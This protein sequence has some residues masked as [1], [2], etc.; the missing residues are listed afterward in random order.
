MN[1]FN[2]DISHLVSK[3]PYG[4]IFLT[5]SNNESKTV[6]AH[7]SFLNSIGKYHTNI[8][9]RYAVEK[10]IDEIERDKKNGG[11]ITITL[12]PRDGLVQQITRQDTDRMS[13]NY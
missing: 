1:T 8:E 7:A 9:A 4:K 11:A 6:S 10:I 12:H 3:V 2:Q 13:F 5:L